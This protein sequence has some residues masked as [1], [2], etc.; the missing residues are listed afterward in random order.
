MLTIAA[1]MLATRLLV[2]A[3]MVPV[4]AMADELVSAAVA[5]MTMMASHSIRP[6]PMMPG[7]VH[8]PAMAAR[9]PGMMTTMATTM[10]AAMST[11]SFGR[12]GPTD[13]DQ[14][15]HDPAQNDCN[16]ASHDSLPLLE[17]ERENLVHLPF[18][19]RAARQQFSRNRRITNI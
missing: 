1:A 7:G 10:T 4:M 11:A 13:H 19:M 18:P 15:H 3:T 12:G 2:H 9:T 5:S 16:P 17:K 8:P 6:A 14:R